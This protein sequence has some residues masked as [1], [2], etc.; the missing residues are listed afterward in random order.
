M[1]EITQPALQR[2]S[3]WVTVLIVLVILAAIAGGLW[4]W[5]SRPIQP[6]VLTPR[7]LAVVEQKIAAI[8]STDTA[9]TPAPASTTLPAST[10]PPAAPGSREPAYERGKKEIVLTEREINGLLNAN[11]DLGQTLLF[12][13]GTDV[14]LARIEADLDPDLPLLGGRKF[15]ARAKFVVS[16]NSGQPSFVI[17][18]LTIWGISLPNEWL[19]GLK[20]RN[21]F[22]ELLGP[23]ANG[24]LP[25]VESFVIRPGE[26][27]I[28]LKE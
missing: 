1:S 4:W 7:E 14:I 21:L 8:Q 13:L 19:G 22:A 15:K 12:Q 25:G 16:E 11:T 28:K 27:S 10:T 26:I 2:R 23:Q 18:D 3:P 20:G 24:E 17:D 5:F 9:V 6:V